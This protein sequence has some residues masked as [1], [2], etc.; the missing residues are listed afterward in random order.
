MELVAKDQAQQGPQKSLTADRDVKKEVSHCSVAQ[1]C[2]SL[3]NDVMWPG[4]EGDRNGED[5]SLE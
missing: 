5:G 3:R 4:R 1:A 2:G